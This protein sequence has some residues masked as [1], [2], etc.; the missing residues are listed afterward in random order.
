MSQAGKGRLPRKD[1]LSRME[2]FHPPLLHECILDQSSSS[3]PVPLKQ[4]TP[5]PSESAHAQDFHDKQQLVHGR[6]FVEVLPQLTPSVDLGP[7]KLMT[8][9]IAII[10][11]ATIMT[12]MVRACSSILAE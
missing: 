2:E 10:I 5:K 7:P 4:D 12:T 6:M 3:L 1:R 11:V 9:K 8:I